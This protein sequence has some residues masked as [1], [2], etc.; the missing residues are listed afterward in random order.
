MIKIPGYSIDKELG[1]GDMASVY[2]ATQVFTKRH[3]AIKIMDPLLGVDSSFGEPFLKEAVCA[4]LK[5]PNVI[6]V[7]DF[8]DT[9]AIGLMHI[10]VPIPALSMVL[11]SSL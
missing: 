9:Y 8:E 3:V 6:T 4:T 5:Q 11:E 2:L 10:S 7:H 1:H